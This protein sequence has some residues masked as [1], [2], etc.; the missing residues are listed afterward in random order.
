MIFKSSF[1]IV[2]AAT[3]AIF[4]HTPQA[5]AHSWMD[6]A[7]WK[8]RTP[9]SKTNK[10]TNGECLGY[11]RRY[12]Y[13]RPFASQDHGDYVR[14]YQQKHTSDSNRLACS[15]GKVGEEP[16]DDETRPSGSLSKAY[17][18]GNKNYGAMTSITAGS[19]LCFRWPAKTHAGDRD[20]GK[21]AI[22][23][24]KDTGKK[25]Y[26]QSE[27]NGKNVANFNFSDCDKAK[28]SDSRPC[29]GCVTL[30]KNEYGPG[31]YLVQWRWR[32]N[33]NEWYTSCA[34]IQINK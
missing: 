27:L 20:G 18:T 5:E 28:S 14:H 22:N 2:L 31:T 25:N 12:P 30:P 1:T 15:D 9:N 10:W 4:S 19:E 7:N 11:A 16:G 32:L 26:K 24:I 23:I 3:L 29:G 13:K 6:C 17:S 8:P 34:D 21:V 33:D